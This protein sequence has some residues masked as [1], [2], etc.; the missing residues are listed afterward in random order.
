M[1]KFKT[2]KDCLDY[3]RNVNYNGFECPHCANKKFWMIYNRKCMECSDCGHQEYLTANTIFH[4]SSTD[5]IKW[6][7]AIQ[8]M[9]QSKKGVS[10]KQLEKALKVTYKTAW[11][12]THKIREAMD[13]DDNDL[14][15]GIIQ[16]DET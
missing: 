10:A 4:K 5:L 7:Y 12:I 6:F 15:S 16:V 8:L 11:R 9:T 14:F 2:E 1:F 13:N 3:L